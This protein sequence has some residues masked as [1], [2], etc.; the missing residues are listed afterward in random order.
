MRYLD[1]VA[2]AT[3][4]DGLIHMNG[5][6]IL[7]DRARQHPALYHSLLR[8]AYHTLHLIGCF[9]ARLSFGKRQLPGILCADESFLW[10][11]PQS[12]PDASQYVYLP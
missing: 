6:W 8:I 10:Y 7:S 9:G 5:A 2:P 11:W 3:E 12:N 4:Y 1:N